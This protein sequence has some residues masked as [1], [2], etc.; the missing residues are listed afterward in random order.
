MFAPP[1]ANAVERM[2]FL[3]FDVDGDTGIDMA[4]FADFQVRFALPP[5]AE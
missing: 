3:V 5:D 4:H 1:F 2:P